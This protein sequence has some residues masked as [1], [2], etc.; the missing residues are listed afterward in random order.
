MDLRCRKET[1]QLEKVSINVNWLDMMTKVIPTRKFEDCYEGAGMEV[2]KEESC[3]VSP[4]LVVPKHSILF[5]SWNLSLIIENILIHLWNK[6]ITF[7][8]SL[9]KMIKKN[10]YSCTI[11]VRSH[12]PSLYN[13]SPVKSRSMLIH[14]VHLQEW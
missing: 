4:K 11:L 12:T 5:L 8:K 13:G 6:E 1:L 9:E 14:L 10:S 2:K 3:W 7:F